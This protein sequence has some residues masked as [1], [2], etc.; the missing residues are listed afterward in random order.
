[1]SEQPADNVT[2]PV[3]GTIH[4]TIDTLNLSMANTLRA[5]AQTTIVGAEF[6]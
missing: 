6:F 1:M 2:V 4:Q 5:V 3:L